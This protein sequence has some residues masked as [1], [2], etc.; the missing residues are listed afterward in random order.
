[1]KLY[2]SPG[3]CS[4]SPHIVLRE[5][6]LPFALEQVDLAT[7]KT[8]R[9]DD[10]SAVNP[11]GQVPVLQLDDGAILTEGPAIVQY[12]ADRNPASGLAPANG[13]LDRYR[14]QEWLNYIT[15]ELHKGFTPLFK[16][17]TPDAYKTITR[18]NLANRFGYLDRHL[19]GRPYIMGERFTVADAYAFTVVGWSKYMKIDLTPWHN[20]KTYMD[21][22]AGRPKVQEAMKAEGLN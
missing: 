22:I 19:A 1:M 7:K 17:N 10:F 20:L 3:A 5:V 15:S 21:R 16:P 18:D 13:T 11:K 4:L 14:L 12:L 8:K 2:F 9:G 6:G